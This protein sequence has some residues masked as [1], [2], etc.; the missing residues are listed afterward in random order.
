M[1]SKEKLKVKTGEVKSSEV[2][3]Q[4]IR[5]CGNNNDMTQLRLLVFCHFYVVEEKEMK[6]LLRELKAF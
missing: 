4:Q 6:Q 1:L 2:M 5:D 3:V